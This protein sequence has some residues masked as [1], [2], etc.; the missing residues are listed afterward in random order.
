MTYDDYYGKIYNYQLKYYNDTIKI[1]ASKLINSQNNIK[2]DNIFSTRS[3]YG[4]STFL[5][6]KLVFDLLFEWKK[7]NIFIATLQHLTDEIY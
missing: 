1:W 7:T 2:D 4:K 5:M 3:N 6:A